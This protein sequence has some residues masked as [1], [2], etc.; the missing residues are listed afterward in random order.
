MSTKDPQRPHGAEATEGAGAE[1][2][3]ASNPFAAAPV[4]GPAGSGPAPDR[5]HAAGSGYS[6]TY[7][8]LPLGSAQSRGFSALRS[9][10]S[11]GSTPSA[12]SLAPGSPPLPLPGSARSQHHDSDLDLQRYLGVLLD[13]R[14]LLLAVLV[15]GVLLAV[16]WTSTQPKIYEARSTVVVEANLPQVLG[17]EVRDIFDPSP[18]SY[19]TMQDFLQTSRR[20]IMSDSL[21]RRVAARLH[22]EREASFFGG[23]TPPSLDVA[24]Q[25]LLGTYTAELVPETR[26]LTVI[27][28]HTRPEWAKK[29]A[30]GVADEFVEGNQQRRDSST[31]TASR[32]LADELDV[33]RKNLHD[34]EVAIYDFKNKH[35]MLSVS[36]EDRAN[37]V[38]RQIDRYTDA[39][40]EIRLRKMQRQT[41]LEELR[42]LRDADPLESPAPQ[43]QGGG[44][45]GLLAEL[46][47]LYIEE[48][49]RVAE[50]KARY[51]DQH[52]LVQQQRG[53]LDQTLKELRREAQLGQLSAQRRYEEAVKDEAKVLAQVESVKQEGLRLTRLEIE[54]NRLKRD[55]DSYQKQYNIILNRTK[56]TGMVGR[57]RLNNLAVLDYARLPGAPVSPKL[58]SAL[59][60]AIVLSLLLGVLL[61][62]ALDVLDRSVKSQEDVEGRLHLPFLGMMPRLETARQA[63]E[64]A[65]PVRSPDLYVA[66]YPRSTVAEACRTIRTNVLFLGTERPLRKLL[67]TSSVA[68]EGKTLSC[69]SLGVVLAQG[70]ARTLII[71]CDLRRP[72]VAKAMGVKGTIGLTNL[73]LGDMKPEDVIQE[74]EV[75]NLWVMASGPIPPNPAELL[76]GLHF[77]QLLEDLAQRYDR[78]L[79]D[80][81]PAGP[82]TDPAVLSTAVDGV[83]LVVRHSSTSRDTVKRAAQAMLDVGG[84]I[85]G[86]VLNDVDTTTKGYRSYYGAYY[87]YYQSEAEREADQDD[88]PEGDAAE[89]KR[90]SE[91]RREDKRESKRKARAARED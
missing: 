42:R 47:R 77:R 11:L 10:S 9:S 17:G 39:L 30:D 67:V 41:Q 66:H 26:L 87:H 38:S 19:Y 35:D 44:D 82:V 1:Q 79:I 48:S 63:P 76:D 60:V 29:I 22:L 83:V 80:S 20:V 27:A 40:T 5:S 3:G 2:S 81:P 69:V 13:R 72:R 36:L 53:K 7:S 54:Y 12:S 15:V 52:P 16:G 73:L 18:G 25:A 57:L 37:Q 68:R 46:R 75:P 34:A 88:Q 78:V 64:L 31:Q 84:R 43:L 55:S 91:A 62:F 89:R 61:V 21:S 58:R 65:G 24:G 86:V 74:S 70:G 71:D 90:A 85:L 49:R 4:K 28:R 50:L 8:T 14:W 33:L 23:A 6:G 51:Q 56:E 45:A 59:G 32:Q